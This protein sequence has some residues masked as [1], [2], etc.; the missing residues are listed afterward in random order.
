V[1][2]RQLWRSRAH[3]RSVSGGPGS[4]G[5]ARGAAD[6]HVGV[7]EQVLRSTDPKY[8]LPDPNSLP[9]STARPVRT[10][11]SVPRRSRRPVLHWPP[12]LPLTPAAGTGRSLGQS[13]VE[14]LSSSVTGRW[15]FSFSLS[16]NTSGRRRHWRTSRRTSRTT[17]ICSRTDPVAV[18]VLTGPARTGRGGRAWRTAGRGPISAGISPS[19]GRR[20]SSGGASV[21]GD[22]TGVNTAAVETAYPDV[23]DPMPWCGRSSWRS[24]LSEGRVLARSVA[25]RGFIPSAAGS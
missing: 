10:E 4:A 19:A 5:A 24:S 23:W 21:D 20:G 18:E 6:D 14:G 2:P 15:G 11:R 13:R 7:L 12:R 9:S 22:P 8:R 3:R 17:P 16:W 25:G 1:W